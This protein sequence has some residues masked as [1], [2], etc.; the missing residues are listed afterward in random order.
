MFKREADLM[1]HVTNLAAAD[2]K[3]DL[4]SMRGT[5]QTKKGIIKKTDL[6]DFSRPRQNGINAIN[7]QEGDE[8]LEAKM[9]D[10]NCEI[11]LAIKSGRAIRFPEEKVRSTGR[12]GIGVY[13]IE[14]D[15][16][17]EEMAD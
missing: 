14:V 6:E 4:N 15:D 8:L 16:E 7:I 5:E 1:Q 13:G 10:G 12:G 11:M 17:K 2:A 3:H 9:T